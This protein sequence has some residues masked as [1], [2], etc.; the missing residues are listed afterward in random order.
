MAFDL[1]DDEA[2]EWEDETEEIFGDDDD[3]AADDVS[4]FFDEFDSLDRDVEF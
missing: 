2:Y 4:E 3:D 1:D